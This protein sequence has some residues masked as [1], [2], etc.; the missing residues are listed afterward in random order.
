MDDWEVT[1]LREGGWELQD[2][3]FNPCSHTT[4]WRVRTQR[5]TSS[6]PSTPQPNEDMGFLINTLAMGLQLGAPCV[7]TFSIKATPGKM[8]VSFEQW[9]HE[10]QCTKD[11]YPKSV[12]R[13]SIVQLLKGA[14]ADMARYMGPTTSVAHILQKL[15]YFW[16]CG[17]I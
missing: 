3:H 15:S 6:P 2:N 13:E 11:H 4:R 16:H 7:N 12:V 17:T 10:V 9:Y 14:V 5:T 8:E 1:F